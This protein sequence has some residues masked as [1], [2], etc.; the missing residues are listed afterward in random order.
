MHALA[1][2]I[3]P[4]SVGAVSGSGAVCLFF[5]SRVRLYKYLIEQRLADVNE[6]IIAAHATGHKQVKVARV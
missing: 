4:F 1:G 6:R 3:L 2:L 5:R